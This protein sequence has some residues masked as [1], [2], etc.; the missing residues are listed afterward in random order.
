MLS[1]VFGVIENDKAPFFRSVSYKIGCLSTLE[2]V[3]RLSE[4]IGS[5]AGV[6]GKLEEEA[7]VAELAAALAR[8]PG[9]LAS[10]KSAPAAFAEMGNCPSDP[11]ARCRKDYLRIM[12]TILDDKSV[13]VDVREFRLDSRLVSIIRGRIGQGFTFFRPDEISSD[14]L[15]Q[16]LFS[17]TNVVNKLDEKRKELEENSEL[18]QQLDFYISFVRA[19]LS[20]V[21]QDPEVK[22]A[23]YTISFWMGLEQISVLT[24]IFFLTALLFGAWLGDLPQ[25]GAKKYLLAEL[26]ATFEQRFAAAPFSDVTEFRDRVRKNLLT[27]AGLLKNSA[28]FKRIF[29]TIRKSPKEAEFASLVLLPFF[30]LEKAILELKRDEDAN[31]FPLETW[32]QQAAEKIEDSRWLFGWCLSALPAI[33]FLSTL[34]GILSALGGAGAV[35]AAEGRLEQAI[36]MDTISGK[37]S[38]AFSTTIIAL[39][40]LLVLS[41]LD[42]WQAKTQR[43]LIED[44]EKGLTEILLPNGVALANP[45]NAEP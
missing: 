15:L 10:G 17:R 6:W 20:A 37:L 14:A 36:A 33:G 38:I 44:V 32:C 39:S 5:K 43:R 30:L 22:D 35:S 9:T 4:A 18:R 1:K 12:K 19:L 21:G 23:S 42:Q 45:G 11:L 7:L 34:Y 26:S 28:A 2:L 41:L 8:L 40:G 13:P 24:L 16:A 29:E 3:L 31:P 27:P 25:L